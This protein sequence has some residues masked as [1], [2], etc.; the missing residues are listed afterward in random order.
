MFSLVNL[1]IHDKSVTCFP[2]STSIFGPKSSHLTVEYVWFV[3]AFPEYIYTFMQYPQKIT[4]RPGSDYS[5]TI[6]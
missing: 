2:S 3:S 4:Q 5:T 6:G 1:L